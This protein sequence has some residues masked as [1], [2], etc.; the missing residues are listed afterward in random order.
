MKKV[1]AVS[2]FAAAILAIVI[3]GPPLVQAQEGKHQ[4]PTTPVEVVSPVPLPVQGTVNIANMPPA[5]EPVVL[6]DFESCAT[7]GFSCG[8]SV[9][10]TVPAGKRLTIESVSFFI[11]KNSTQP[12]VIVPFLTTTLGGSTIQFELGSFSEASAI[13]GQTGVI[14]VSDDVTLYADPETTVRYGFLREVSSSGQFDYNL[15]ADVVGYLEPV[16]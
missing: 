8:N 13:G 6:T 15:A 5:R 16:S 12:D 14:I 1:T 3:A 10:Y 2:L 9:L 4:R 7:N 11:T